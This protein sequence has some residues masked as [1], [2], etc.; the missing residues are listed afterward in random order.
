[1]N[2]YS[3]KTLLGSERTLI[4]EFDS[5]PALECQIS[6]LSI[7]DTQADNKQTILGEKE[8]VKKSNQTTLEDK[9]AFIS[10]VIHRDFDRNLVIRFI[11]AC[12]SQKDL[13]TATGISTSTISKLKNPV[14]YGPLEQSARLL[15]AWVN[16]KEITVVKE[17][18]HISLNSLEAMTNSLSLIDLS[19]CNIVYSELG[20]S[21]HAKSG[22]LKEVRLV[23][24][25]VECLHSMKGTFTRVNLSNNLLSDEGLSVLA[26]ELKEHEDLEEIYLCNNKISDKGLE[27]SLKQLLLLPHLKILDISQNYGPS[28][29]TLQ[30]LCEGSKE[31]EVKIK[32]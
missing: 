3:V 26:A 19:N 15:W 22:F 31:I 7:L 8:V 11:H 28:T 2:A 17:K 13:S 18:L 14:Q 1:M 10:K 6:E 32:Y 23:K 20:K 24:D 29:K 16:S 12:P 9:E 27:R 30:V 4:K 21:V 5:I 25:V